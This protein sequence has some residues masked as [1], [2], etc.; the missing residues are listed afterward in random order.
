MLDSEAER[1]STHQRNGWGYDAAGRKKKAEEKDGPAMRGLTVSL[2]HQAVAPL[3]L[4]S[5]FQRRGSNQ[6]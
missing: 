4:L 6:K 3:N 5:A 1:N 2:R